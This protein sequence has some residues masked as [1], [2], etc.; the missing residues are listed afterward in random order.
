MVWL[1]VNCSFSVVATFAKTVVIVSEPPV[2][3]AAVRV[4]L[5]LPVSSPEVVLPVNSNL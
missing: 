4:T 3:V 5:L 2:P 1:S